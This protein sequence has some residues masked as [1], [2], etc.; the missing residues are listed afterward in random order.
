MVILP[1][2]TIMELCNFVFA[3]SHCYSTIV[4]DAALKL[5]RD[6]KESGICQVRKAKPGPS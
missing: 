5:L 4:T 2:V 1:L 3:C 6:R